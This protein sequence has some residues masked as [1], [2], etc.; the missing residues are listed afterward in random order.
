MF[1]SS[2]AFHWDPEFVVLKKQTPW[3]RL[4]EKLTVS[5]L[6]KKFLPP[7]VLLYAANE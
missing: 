4:R 6:V 1:F 7:E 5:Y 2:F 3:G